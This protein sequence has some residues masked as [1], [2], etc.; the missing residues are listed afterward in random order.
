MGKIRATTTYN[1]TTICS[2]D[3]EGSNFIV[4]YNGSTIATIG[5]GETK[6][7]NCSD[8]LM[9]SNIVIGNKTLNCAK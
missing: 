7:L 4:T 9:R 1:N 8:K 3:K 6:T 5:V 2:E